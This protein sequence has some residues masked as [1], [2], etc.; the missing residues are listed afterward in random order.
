MM[1][2]WL[3]A[4]TWD[5]VDIQGLGRAGLTLHW[6]P[7]SGELAPSYTSSSTV[8]GALSLTQAAVM[9]VWVNQPPG[10]ECGRPDPTT[11]LM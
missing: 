10:C 3:R 1:M 4:A 7:H 9:E 11:H 6:L 8:S 2:S 5:D